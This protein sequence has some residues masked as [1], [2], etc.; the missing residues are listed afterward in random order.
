MTL[1]YTLPNFLVL[2]TLIFLTVPSHQQGLPNCGR[3][4]ISR[5]VGGSESAP[6]EFPWMVHIQAK[7]WDGS[8]APCG[9]TLISKDWVLTAA[10]C[11]FEVINAKLTLGAHDI[12]NTS[13]SLRINV[14]RWAFVVHPSWYAWD[15]ENNI[16]LIRL[17]FSVSPSVNIQAACLP[18]VNDPD[19]VNDN[20]VVTGWGNFSYAAGSGQSPVLRKMDTTVVSSLG[21]DGECQQLASVGPFSGDNVICGDGSLQRHYCYG[22]DGGPMN[23]YNQEW[24]R[25]FVIGV[26]G[27]GDPSL[28]CFQGTDEPNVFVRV[29]G[30]LNWIEGVT[31]LKATTRTSTTMQ[32]PSTTTNT[33][34]NTT[35]PT[36]PAV[37][38]YNRNIDACDWPSNVAGCNNI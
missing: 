35:L 28:R 6:N 12:T 4:A 8:W 16:A 37:T 36:T 22:D 33:T 27:M 9:G 5:I 21:M 34:P 26:A 19:Q 38:V 29:R 20:V 7:Y 23:Y 17:P 10:H 32:T 13:S 31:G 2:T 11:L 1:C 15:V 14:D 30:Y 24:D 3:S 25:W 18:F